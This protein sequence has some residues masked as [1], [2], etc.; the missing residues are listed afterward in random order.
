MS[1]QKI[2]DRLNEQQVLCPSE[3][4]KSLGMTYKT[5]M[6]KKTGFCMDGNCYHK[7]PDEQS[8]YR[9]FGSG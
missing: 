9:L 7:D 4:K 8:V 6:K 3:Y 1:N 5:G 2:A